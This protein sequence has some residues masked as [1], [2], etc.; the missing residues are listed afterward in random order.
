MKLV[1][2]TSRQVTPC[3]AKRGRPSA[4]ELTASSY[5][6][7]LREF[8][9]A[10]SATIRS[11]G[12][13]RAMRM[14]VSTASSIAVEAI[15][16]SGPCT[17]ETMRGVMPN[18]WI[19]GLGVIVKG[20]VTVADVAATTGLRANRQQAP[21]KQRRSQQHRQPWHPCASFSRDDSPGERRGEAPTSGPRRDIPI[22]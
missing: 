22:R 6:V 3:S 2:C 12:R 16:V 11:P 7:L 17:A 15:R 20:D 10:T 18:S 19:A 4:N 5:A 21:C 8:V 14:E 13:D 9:V 1:G